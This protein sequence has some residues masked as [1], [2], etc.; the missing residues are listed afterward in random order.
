MLKPSS[1]CEESARNTCRKGEPESQQ[2]RASCCAAQTTFDQGVVFKVAVVSPGRSRYTRTH[3]LPFLPFSSLIVQPFR[4]EG[5]CRLPL[6]VPSISPLV[7]SY[8]P[9]TATIVVHLLPNPEASNASNQQ[10]VLR[11][12]PPLFYYAQ[13]GDLYAVFVLSMLLSTRRLTAV[14]STLQNH[15]R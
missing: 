15:S 3:V 2:G 14:S 8:R 10:S 4:D 9:S 13:P 11:T 5:S 7:I 12:C 1:K 6:T